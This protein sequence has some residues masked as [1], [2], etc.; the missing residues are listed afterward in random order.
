[1][2][3]NNDSLARTT[4]TGGTL[5]IGG[6]DYKFRTVNMEDYGKLETYVRECWIK[7]VRELELPPEREDELILKALAKPVDVD[8]E[9]IT[10]RG[11]MFLLACSLDQDP[12]MTPE[13]LGKM[14]EPA[15]ALGMLA[16][17]S[18]MQD[19]PTPGEAEEEATQ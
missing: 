7:R 12:N 9:K 19:D 3:E 16:Q 4:G 13:T 14:L 1:M 5:T 17:A 10:V 18:G 8:E 6:K 15:D 11:A 2:G